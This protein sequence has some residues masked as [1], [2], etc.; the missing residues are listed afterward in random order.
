MAIPRFM[1]ILALLTT[2]IIAF[3]LPTRLCAADTSVSGAD[4]A[5]FEAISGMSN[6]QLFDRATQW[7]DSLPD[8]ALLYFDIIANRYRQSMAEDDARLC[9][10]ALLNSGKIFYDN[11]NYSNAMESLLKCRKVCEDN[12]FQSILSEAYR[13]IGNIYSRHSDYERAIAFYDKSLGIADRIADRELIHMTLSNLV[14]ANIFAGNLDEAATYYERLCDNRYDKPCYKYDVLVDG[15]LLAMQNDNIDKALGMM[16]EASRYVADNDF[17]VT[18][19]GSVNSWLAGLYHSMERTD[20]TLYY[21]HLNEKLARQHGQIDLL[22]E[23]LRFL[24]EIHKS[25]G[26]RE[27]A[28]AYLEEYLALSDSIFNQKVFNSLKNAQFQYDLDK[29]DGIIRNLNDEKLRQ[30]IHIEQQRTMLWGISIATLILVALFL[31]IYRQKRHISAA[32]TDL[33]ERNRANLENEKAYRARI[34]ELQQQ[35]TPATPEPPQPASAGQ[36][37]DIT[38]QLRERLKRDITEA[39]DRTDLF[40]DPSFTINRLAD[41]VKSNTTYVSRVINETY[42]MNF[43]AF[44]NEYRIKESMNRLGSDGPYANF[45]IK[46]IAESVGFKSQSAFIAAFTKF[47]GMKPSM[48]QEIAR[49]QFS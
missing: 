46:A 1:R 4:K 44:L 31:V 12:N 14:G 7:T 8:S 21:L 26:N 49:R 42:G 25:K 2:A 3:W 34:R 38:P 17:D 39:M 40:C 16:T 36:S 11:F 18:K 43:R 27:L 22:A 45:T 30:E 29:S 47:T 5:R 24:S 33:F 37:A 9:A 13:Y 41:E 19:I 48:Y 15:G 35:L 28:I 23:T 6:R 32:Y 10:E 20:S